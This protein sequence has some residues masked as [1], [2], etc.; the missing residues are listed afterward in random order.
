M[1]AVQVQ[2]I[3][4]DDSTVFTVDV[5]EGEEALLRRIAELSRKVS[6]YSCQPRLVTGSPGQDDAAGDGAP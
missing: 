1:T 6:T 5:T 4:C 2:L 3:G